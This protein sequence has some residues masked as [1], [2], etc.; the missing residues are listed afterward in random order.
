[1]K[2]KRYVTRVSE[3]FM[4]AIHG[5][6][7]LIQEIFVPDA[8]LYINKNYSF[9]GDSQRADEI[10]KFDEVEV[11]FDDVTELVNAIKSKEKT[12]EKLRK[13][14]LT[15]TIDEKDYEETRCSYCH[16]VI[17]GIQFSSDNKYP[18][19]VFCCPDHANRWEESNS[20]CAYCNQMITANDS[21]ITI[22]KNPEAKFCSG[23]CADFW[24]KENNVS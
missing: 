1:M 10:T 5:S 12:E 7:Y 8:G 4:D 14:L 24:E 3:S 16:C 2:G 21:Y 22:D 11:N 13:E 20:F 19:A 9:L 15:L 18:D 23:K 17:K 6:S